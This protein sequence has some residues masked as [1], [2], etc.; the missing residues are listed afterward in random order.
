MSRAITVFLTLMMLTLITLTL[1]APVSLTA[2]PLEERDSGITQPKGAWSVGLFNPLNWQVSERVGLEVHPLAFFAAPHLTLSHQLSTHNGHHISAL[3]G[4][5]APSWAL[6]NSLPFGLRGYLGP[7]CL[8][9]VAEPEREGCQESGWGLSPLLGARWAHK[10]GPQVLTATL[11]VAVGVML[12]GDRPTPLDTYAPVEVLFAPLTNTWRAHLGARAARRI[13]D[14]L[15]LSLELNVW[16]TGEGP[17]LGLEAEPKSPWVLS[18]H[19][20]ADIALTAHLSATLGVIYYNSDQRA[21]RYV[22]DSEGYAQQERVRSHDVWPT[23]DLMWS[24]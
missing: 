2:R 16:R 23:L 3:Y 5:S 13:A 14:R 6:K 17:A 12:S 10:Q 9:S 8:V 19:A 7:S 4:L 15:S 24:Y 20:G 11:D 1:G 21:T 22:L 18:A